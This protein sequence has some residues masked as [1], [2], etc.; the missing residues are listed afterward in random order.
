MCQSKL[1][2]LK[3]RHRT[4]FSKYTIHGNPTKNRGILVL[5][6]RHNG[7][8]ITNIHNHGSNDTLYFTLIFPD[9][10]TLDTLVVYAPSKDSPEFWENANT[11]LNTGTSTHKLLIGDF[12]CTLSHTLDQK[13]YKT[14]PH[15]KSRKVL[16]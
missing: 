3:K 9:L 8:K 11:I 6:K 14:D 7:C 10:T 12:N 2:T 4:L 1:E 13:G 5:L 16:N 15:P